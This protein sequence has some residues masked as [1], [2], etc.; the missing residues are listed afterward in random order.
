[1]AINNGVEK[2]LFDFITE[3]IGST[4]F[5]KL[6]GVELVELGV[7]E[8]TLKV[9]TSE[10]HTNPLGKI[11]GGLLMSIADAAMGNAIRSLGYKSVSVDVSTSFMSSATVGDEI[12]AKG[13][14]LKAGR[15][16]IF[17]EAAVIS[18]DKP[19]VQCK[20]TFYNLGEIREQ[21]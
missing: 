9:K 4:S 11:H 8:A 10:E 16:L 7:G 21:E 15:N 19:I 13:T 18:N 6:L 12:L 17:A 5:Y 2:W 20:G 14:I 3:S 1:M